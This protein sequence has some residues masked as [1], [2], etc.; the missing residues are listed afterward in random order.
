M[1]ITIDTREQRPWSFPEFVETEIG[2]LQTGDYA[3]KGD[4]G[5][6]IERKSVDDFAGTISTGWPRFCREIR[7]MDDAGFPAK[8]IIVEADFSE[9]CFRAMAG[10]ILPPVH[11]H[12]QLLPQF[13]MKRVAELTMRGCSVLFC[14]SAALASNMALK[15]FIEREKAI[16]EYDNNNR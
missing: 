16:Y 6:A 4:A 13:I 10:E 9:F 7:R 3:I 2:T 12:V 11:E 5:F 15:I 1:I 14:G 8:V